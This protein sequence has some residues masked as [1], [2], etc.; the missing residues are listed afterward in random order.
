M[1]LPNGYGSVYKMPGNR[2]KPWA[3]R[4]TVARIPQKNGGTRWKYKYLGYYDTQADALNALA[5]YNQNPY[6][7]DA[8]KITF[9]EV[10]EKWS[11]EH[12]P[13][14]SKSNVQGYNAAFKLCDSIQTLKFH[15][16][17]KSHMQGVIDASGKNYPTLRKAKVL[18]NMMYKFAL[19]ND[20]CTKDYSQYIDILQYKD[21]NPNTISRSPFSDDE[22][23]TMWNWVD[24]NEYISVILMMIYSGVRIG[25]LR[26]LKKEDVHL[27]DRYFYIAKAKTP[28]GVRNVPIA[29]KVLPFFQYW[30]DKPSK[31]DFLITTRE[32]RYFHDRNY[33]DSYWKPLIEEMGLNAD[34]KPHDTRHT[35]VSLLTREGV[36]ERLIKKIVGHAGAG[37]TEQVYTHIE[38]Q[39][40]MAEIDKI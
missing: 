36:D 17:R 22:I 12:Y 26:E 15:E 14:V 37:V 30:M 2:R 7:L 34:H 25:E 1:K 13:K 6:D 32:G 4:I 20:I 9:A 11:T 39:Q 35:C 8:N 29:K 31:C 24:K 3:V 40:L 23:K 28:A 19:E 38:M 5:H 18:F 27:D 33:R 21:K 16:I 10:F